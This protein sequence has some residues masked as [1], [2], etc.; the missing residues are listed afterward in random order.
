MI[1]R[2]RTY[3]G[4]REYPKY[5][6]VSRYFVYKQALLE[7]A[8]RLAQADVLRDRDDIF[9]LTFQELHDVV[10]TK[11]V[12]DDLIRSRKDD[13]QVVPLAHAAPGAHLGWRGHRRGLPAR[14]RA[15]RCAHRPTGLRRD[16]R[17]TGPRHPGHGAG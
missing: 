11:H 13:V 1:D 9:Y 7:E 8:E 6:M 16:R 12:D 4:Y 15:D 5:G 14:R 2:L 3:A 10:R 17:R